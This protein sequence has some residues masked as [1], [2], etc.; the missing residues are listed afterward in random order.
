MKGW[1]FSS[2]LKITWQE[3]FSITQGKGSLFVLLR[4]LTDWMRP[5]HIRE[6]NLFT[7]YTDLIINIIEKHTK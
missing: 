6:S 2:D 5:T 7:Q 3:E 1:C 4:P